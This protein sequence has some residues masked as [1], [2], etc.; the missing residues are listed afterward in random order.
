MS[1]QV[2]NALYLTYLGNHICKKTITIQEYETSVTNDKLFYTYCSQYGKYKFYKFLTQNGNSI[3]A[4]RIL[5]SLVESE[6][7][8]AVKLP[9]S[10]IGVYAYLGL[11]DDIEEIDAEEEIPGKAIKVK[12]YIISISNSMLRETL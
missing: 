7:Y 8:L 2:L 4:R 1:K 6:E 11:S 9:F 10:Q 3:T 5:V 12:T